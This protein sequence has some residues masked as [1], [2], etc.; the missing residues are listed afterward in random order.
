MYSS[1]TFTSEPLRTTGKEAIEQTHSTGKRKQA[2]KET[3]LVSSKLI[4]Y[5]YNS[6]ETKTKETTLAN[7]KGHRQSN[8]P[9]KTEQKYM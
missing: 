7:H 5:F 8:E 1:L 3:K 6:Q 2:H 4:T 9:I